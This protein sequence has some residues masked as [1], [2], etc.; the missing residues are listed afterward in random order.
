MSEAAMK[1]L[2]LAVITLLLL[3]GCDRPRSAGPGPG[4][5]E[6]A[7]G[8]GEGGGKG[9]PFTA[10]RFAMVRDQIEG[11]GV[12]DPRVLRAMRAVERHR[13][14]PPEC[15]PS[16]YEDHPLPIGYGQTISQPLIVAYMTEKAA[17]KTSDRVLEVGTGSG[18]QAAVLS[19]LAKEVYTVEIL[20]PLA[21]EAAD[22]LKKLG[23]A[24][25]V[26]RVGDGWKGWPEK[27]PFD[28]ILVTAA[29]PEVPPDLVRQLAPGGRMVVP[30]GGTGETQELTLVTRD[31]EGRVGYE[32]LL[33]VRFVPLV[34]GAR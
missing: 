33:P 10:A 34:H 30:V 19:L 9:D 2:L 15:V 5:A 17:V 18:Y 7:A 21:L 1:T 23:Y 8:Y 16:A 27:A 14:V 32:T 3:P 29:P 31:T 26:C 4:Y 24:N 28:V 13:F 11:R 22:R 25:V 6:D 12:R 20:E